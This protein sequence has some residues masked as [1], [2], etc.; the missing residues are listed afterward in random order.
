M[1]NKFVNLLKDNI[2]IVII[3]FVFFC[4][5]IINSVY[6]VGLIEDGVH[7]FWEAITADNIFVG[8]EGTSS[9]PYNS[10][11][12]PSV[13]SHLITGLFVLSGVV[14]IK[15]LLIIFTFISYFVP[16]IFLYF[17]YLNITD[18]RKNIFEIILLS[19][20]L[21]II[22][23]NYQIWTENFMTSLF[24]WNIF[25]I[26][27][28]SDFSKL[29]K[30]NLISLIIFPVF[31]I[32]SHPMVVVF[33]PFLLMYTI[34]KHYVNKT[35][36]CKNN[37]IFLIVSYVLLFVALIFNIYFIINP[38][39]ASTNEYLNLSLLK[40]IKIFAIFLYL[41]LI[42]IALSIIKNA[43][44]KYFIFL[45]LLIVIFDNLFLNIEPNKCYTYRILGFYIP[46]FFMTVL[47]FTKIFKIVYKTTDFRIL[48]ILLLF[49][50]VF[51]SV[52]YANLW[53]KFCL[54][55]E[56]YLKENKY[57]DI[58]YNN[59]YKLFTSQETVFNLYHVHL[60]PMFIMLLEN[61]NNNNNECKIN[62][63]VPD[64]FMVNFYNGC[65]FHRTKQLEKYSIDLNKIISM[66]QPEE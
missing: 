66:Q 40:D 1:L 55:S 42:F 9:F 20:L 34:Y 37:S 27:L 32:S 2:F 22:F 33:I 26:Y 35:K 63:F 62:L 43:K 13:F 5:S 49:I 12:F 24:L 23:L 41:I 7:H 6:N 4:L 65:I 17:I 56:N 28:Y 54:L 51:N 21:E 46:L 19:F 29:S 11:Y 59:N 10:R 48:N 44:I 60:Y 57:I 15:F 16:A 39:F 45:S 3:L 31:L 14:K 50:F 47:F 18:N 30:F 25:V 52:F 64:K 36:I 61:M 8:H 58:A 38:I 53:N